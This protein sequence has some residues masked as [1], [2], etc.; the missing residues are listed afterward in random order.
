M[1]AEIISLN[2]YRKDK[3]RAEKP[4]HAAVN[5]AKSGRTK[6]V[7]REQEDQNLRSE[8]ALDGKQLNDVEDSGGEPA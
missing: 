2:K 8:Q 4:Q 3:A 1:A 6:V 5:R 7:R